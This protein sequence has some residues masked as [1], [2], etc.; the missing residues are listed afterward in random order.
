VKGSCS[1]VTSDS[2][3]KLSTNFPYVLSG[4]EMAVTGHVV[5]TLNTYNSSKCRFWPVNKNM[6]MYQPLK[7]HVRS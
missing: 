6:K 2:G 1:D 5:H 3:P 4:N 7:L